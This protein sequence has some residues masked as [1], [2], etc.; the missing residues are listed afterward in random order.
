MAFK[1][2]QN[3]PFERGL[4]CVLDKHDF[5]QLYNIVRISFYGFALLPKTPYINGESI[6]LLSTH[7]HSLN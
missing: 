1:K 3:H 7:K 6:I 5:L 2:G 4:L